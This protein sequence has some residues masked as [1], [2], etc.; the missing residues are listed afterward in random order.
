MNATR[1]SASRT[2]GPTRLSSGLESRAV[3]DIASALTV[4]L[5]DMFALYIKTKNF[6]WHVGPAFLRLS[7]SLRR[8]E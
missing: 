6:H 8:T 4:I 1:E 3:E 2:L 5:A 7:S